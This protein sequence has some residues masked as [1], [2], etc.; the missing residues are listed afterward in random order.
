[1]FSVLHVEVI[2]SQK[3]WCLYSPQRH[4][5]EINNRHVNH[6]VTVNAMLELMV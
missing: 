3:P 1:M 5:F 2:F 4:R 6:I